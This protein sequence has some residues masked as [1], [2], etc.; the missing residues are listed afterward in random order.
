MVTG[1]K[2]SHVHTG[3][4]GWRLWQGL[5]LNGSEKTFL[6]YL[7]G[8]VLLVLTHWSAHSAPRT[9]PWRSSGLIPFLK[10]NRMRRTRWD[11]VRPET[12]VEHGPWCLASIQSLILVFSPPVVAV[13]GILLLRFHQMSMGSS[14]VPGIGFCSRSL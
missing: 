6:E 14:F 13:T 10:M 4:L 3:W 11:S 5:A 7:G 12:Q 8:P 2:R 1:F 9:A